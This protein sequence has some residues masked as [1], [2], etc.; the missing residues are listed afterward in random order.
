MTPRFSVFSKDDSNI[1]GY[2]VS[3][4]GDVCDI[5]VFA[6]VLDLVPYGC[7][8]LGVVKPQWVFFTSR[9]DRMVSGTGLDRV[10]LPYVF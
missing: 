9:V 4:S 10:S 6:W 1:D 5:I 8:C 2:S 7:T 3:S